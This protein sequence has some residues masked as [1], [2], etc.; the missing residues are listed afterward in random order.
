MVLSRSTIRRLRRLV[1][2]SAEE[3][4]LIFRAAILMFF[5]RISL[6]L[7]GLNRTHSLLKSWRVSRRLTTSDTNAVIHTTSTLVDTAAVSHPLRPTC[8]ERSLVLWTLLRRRGIS[9]RICIG[10]RQTDGKFFAH[11]WVEHDGNVLIDNSDVTQAYKVLIHVNND[12][13]KV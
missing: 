1:G 7:L 9:S 13:M 5:A 3:R 11:A 6:R 10:V 2:L 4:D 8:L 12:L